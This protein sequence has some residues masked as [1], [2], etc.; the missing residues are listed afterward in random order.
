MQTFIHIGLVEFVYL[1]YFKS[2]G[3][4]CQWFYSYF[5]VVSAGGAGM[6]ALH[7]GHDVYTSL[8][9]NTSLYTYTCISS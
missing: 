3:W 4:M 5:A 8:Y 2:D 7:G 6:F 1:N 9:V